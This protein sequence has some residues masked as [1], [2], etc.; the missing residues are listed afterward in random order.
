M[1]PTKQVH[2]EKEII[3]IKTYARHVNCTQL[4]TVS[5]SAWLGGK[6]ILFFYE[7]R[8]LYKILFLLQIFTMVLSQTQKLDATSENIF[9]TDTQFDFWLLCFSLTRISRTISFSFVRRLI[10][11][12]AFNIFRTLELFWK[13][14]MHLSEL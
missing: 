4:A 8:L 13:Q 6:S 3:K 11:L 5:L 14:S 7:L 12:P 1:H 10:Y 9:E 2:A